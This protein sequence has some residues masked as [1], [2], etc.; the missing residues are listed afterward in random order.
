MDARSI[1]EVPEHQLVELL[2]EHSH[3]VH[4]AV[5][6]ETPEPVTRRFRIMPSHLDLPAGAFGDVDAL[7][8]SA[9]DA[10]CARAVESTR[11]KVTTATFRTG[12][13]NKLQELRKA[14]YQVNAAATTGFSRVW[15]QIIVV[16][17]ARQ[18]TA[19]QFHL[20]PGVFEMHDLVRANIPLDG[21]HPAVGVNVMHLVQPVDRPVTESGQFGGAVMRGPEPQVQSS[22]LTRA[23][24]R[25][26]G[27]RA[28]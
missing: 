5:P 26:F 28:A 8:I 18:V 25:L 7:L 4:L 16:M 12:E 14:C 1:A 13:P 15:L 3:L 2:F 11:I 17:D 6:P 21:L 27:L 10:S 20:V 9:N 24:D 23:I 19:G 22:T